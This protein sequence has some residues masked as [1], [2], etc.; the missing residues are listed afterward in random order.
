MSAESPQDLGRCPDLERLAAFV[1]GR[2]ATPERT[3][4]ELHLADCDA[5]RELL[6]DTLRFQAEQ[7]PAETSGSVRSAPPRARQVAAWL[8]AASL[9]VAAGLAVWMAQRGTLSRGD[10]SSVELAALASDPRRMADL[11]DTWTRNEWSVSRGSSPSISARA[12]SFRLGVRSVDLELAARSEDPETVHGLALEMAGLCSS[13]PFAD[14]V[15]LTYLKLAERSASQASKSGIPGAVLEAN[16][17]ARSSNDEALFELGRWAETG[18]LVRRSA[19]EGEPV[20]AFRAP[21]PRRV[22]QDLERASESA[23]RERTEAAFSHL[24]LEGGELE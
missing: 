4:V 15:R 6:A 10:L 5:C 14:P 7:T 1:D 22:P 19:V 12:A 23:A 9:A 20:P 11:G 16:S 2:L 13:I 8:A 24:V 21:L 18:R 17:L 3:Q